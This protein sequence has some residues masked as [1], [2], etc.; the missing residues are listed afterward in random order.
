MKK[1]VYRAMLLEDVLVALM[2]MER[3][4]SE[5]QRSDAF[6]ILTTSQRLEYRDMLTRLRD[7][8]NDLEQ[9]SAQ[10]QIAS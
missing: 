2:E 5:L 10:G 1:P 6:H 8:I 4:A 3:T 9:D 7:L